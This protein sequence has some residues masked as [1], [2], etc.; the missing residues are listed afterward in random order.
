[1]TAASH[2]AEPPAQDGKPGGPSAAVAVP[3][4]RYVIFLLLAG[5]GLGADLGTK[6]WAFGRL[7]MPDQNSRL[8]VVDGVLALETSLNEGALFGFGQ[9][10]VTLFAA[11][12]VVAALGIVYWLFAAGAAYDLLLTIA[13]GCV[14]AG[15]CGNLYD[16]LGLPGLT[17]S[18][19]TQRVD[20]PVRAVRDWIHF[21]IDDVIDW[22]VFNIADSL[23]V[24]GAALLLWHALRHDMRRAPG[25]AGRE[26]IAKNE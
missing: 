9:G 16:R 15:I 7:G 3:P 8:V 13:L 18:Y 19:P 6:S 2:N 12:S 17:W 23:L 25:T 1:M 11:L 5:F 21:K 20:E 14:M 4:N 22:P 26:A 10:K 24:C